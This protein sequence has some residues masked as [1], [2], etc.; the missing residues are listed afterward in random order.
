MKFYELVDLLRKLD[1]FR[2]SLYLTYNNWQQLSMIYYHLGTCCKSKLSELND[3]S[4]ILIL[5]SLFEQVRQS[6]NHC[7]SSEDLEDG[8][9]INLS[10]KGEDQQSET[11]PSTICIS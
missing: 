4:D 1:L 5:E 3:S 11:K 6:R 10:N 9:I 8:E 2:S 7:D